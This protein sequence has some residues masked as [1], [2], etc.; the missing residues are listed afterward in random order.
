MRDFDEMSF[1]REFSRHYSQLQN[2]VFE[3]DD[4]DAVAARTTTILTMYYV[5]SRMNVL[6]M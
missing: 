4:F 1:V 2:Q 6:F 5:A 3:N